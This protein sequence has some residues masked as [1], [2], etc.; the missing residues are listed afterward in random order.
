MY[1]NM[2]TQKDFILEGQT[3]RISNRALQKWKSK[4]T[5]TF[6]FLAR[7]NALKNKKL[8]K[9]AKSDNNFR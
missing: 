5:P 3:T 4:L 9:A 7:M 2:L 1:V 8:I 6:Y